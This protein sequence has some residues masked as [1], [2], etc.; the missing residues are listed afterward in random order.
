MTPVKITSTLN[1]ESIETG[2]RCKHGHRDATIFYDH[3]VDTPVLADDCLDLLKRIELE[4][5]ATLPADHGAFPSEARI[6]AAD[7]GYSLPTQP[8][9]G[10]PRNPFSRDE[11]CEKFR[12]YTR[13]IIGVDQGC[14]AGRGHDRQP[15]TS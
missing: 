2:K 9:K 15:H 10:S 1:L 5:D 13:E 11:I 6:E 7:T 4:P 14:G 8:H 3:L 12:R